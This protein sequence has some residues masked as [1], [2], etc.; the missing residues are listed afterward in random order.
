MTAMTW[1]QRSLLVVF[2]SVAAAEAAAQS[3]KEAPLGQSV[4]R[5]LSADEPITQWLH[6]PKF[7]ET[8]AGDRFELR[9]VDG[10]ALETVKLKNVIPPIR[11]ASG[12]AD[13]PDQFVATLRKTLDSVRER[14]N[15]RLHLVGHA[16]TQP[17]SDALARIYG[18]NAG[19]SRERAGEVAEYLQRALMLPPDA[20]TYEWA[21][22]TQ[23]IAT[24]ASEEGRALNRRVEVEVWYDQPTARTT[25]EEVLVTND[26]K[27]V[28]VCRVETLCKLRFREGHARRARVKNLVPPLHYESDTTDLTPEFV[29]HVR[30]ALD[31]LRD[32]QNVVVKLI[33]YTDDAPL[34][35]RDARIYGD[36]LALSKAKAYR[37]A[38]ALAETLEL[39]SGVFASDGRGTT[40]PLARND[41]SQGRA[42]NR[43]VEV[44]FWHD[45]PLQE[46]PDEPQL[47]PKTDGVE[48]V[49][50]VYDPP[51]GTI[52]PLALEHG[53]AVIPAG[54]VEQLRR[55][56]NEIS[57]KANAR[58]RFVGYTGNEVLD[59]RTAAVYGDDIG[60]STARARRAMQTVSARM[61]LA[62][63]QAEHEGR[64]YVHS[65]DV[66]NAGFTQERESIVMVQAVYDEPAALDDY[67]GVDITP[68]TR[69]LATKNAFGLNLMHISVD[70]EPIDD[71]NRSSA[72]VQRCTDVA[73]EAA[74]IQ[75]RFDNLTSSPRLSVSAAPAAVTVRTLDRELAIGEPVRF[76]MYANYWSFI[77]HAEVRI[78]RSDQSVDDAPQGLVAVD[79]HGIAEWQ[80]VVPR[81]AVSTQGFKYVL[82]AY[83]KDGQFDDTRPQLLSV[84]ETAADAAA[85]TEE[86]NDAYGAASADGEAT[87]PDTPLGNYGENQL[88][89]Q[90]IRLGSGTVKV[91]GSAIPPDYRVWV[92]GRPVPVDAS[93]NF[94]AEAVL[95]SGMHTVEVAVLDDDGNGHLYLR[96]L[97][98]P[99]R[100]RFY[101]G[102]ADL[103][104]SENRTNGPADLL[105]GEN[106]PFDPDSNV[107]GRLAFYATEKLADHW[108]VTA[109]ADTREGPVEDLF[110]NF[111]DKSPDSLF[112]RMDPDIHYPTFGDDAI[113]E[114]MAPT[115]GKLYVKVSHDESHAMWGNFKVGY[116]ENELAQVDR[117]LYGGNL[118]WQS[119]ATTSFGEQRVALD[120]FAAEPGTVASREEFRGTGGSLYFLHNQDILTGSERVRIE[121]RD[122]DSGLVTGVVNLQ[123]V[124]DY[125]I[126][127][128]QGRILLSEPL[129]STTDDDMLVRSGGLSGQHAYL[130]VRYE[131]TPGL[132]DIDAMNTGGQASAWVTDW[133]K[134]GITT[135]DNDD[136]DMDSSLRGGDL[137]LRKSANTYLKLQGGKSEGLLMSSF[138]SED[139]GF[140][141]APQDDL[142]MN[143]ASADGYRADLAIGFEDVYSRAK[144]NLM[145]YTQQ[146][147]A[148]YSAPG[149]T[150]LADRDNYGATLH[151]PFGERVE[152][153]AKADKKWQALGLE[154]QTQEVDIAFQMTPKWSLATG[155][156]K[157]ARTDDSPVVPV[158]QDTGDRTDAVV[159][160][161]YDSLE[162]W[163]VYTF[164]QDTLST[165]DERE[166]N[167]RF[168]A[169][170]SYRFG[171]KLRTSMEV[172][173]GDLGLG[174]KVGT[175]YMVNEATDVY[176]NYSLEQ[177]GVADGVRGR[178]RS[179]ISGVKRRLSDSTSMYHEERYQS[180]STASGLTHATGVTLTARERW[181]FGANSE[182]GTLSN[183]ETG[184]ETDRKAGGIRVAYDLANVQLS[185]GVEY[186]FDDTE[187]LDASKVDRTTWLFRNNF[188]VQLGPDWR[189]VGKVDHSQSDSSL[190]QFYDG[191]YT[192]AVLGYGYRPVANDRLN[193]LVKY[194]YFYN[195]PT[196]DQVTPQQLAAEYIQKSHIASIDVTYDLTD[197]WTI[198]GKYAY[199]IG[200]LSLDRDDPEFFDNGAQLYIVRA[201]W[202]LGEKW[203]GMVEA[204]MLDLPDLDEQRA[205]ALVGLY[206]Y[207]GDHVKVGVGY[208]FTD[209]SEDLTDLSYDSHGA[210]LNIVGSM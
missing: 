99:K 123:P 26:F 202:R 79:E 173:D 112:R 33:G 101:V 178:G 167:D 197:R 92:A 27:K 64:G 3:T 7:F 63:T 85:D 98:L 159:Q 117:G 70:G 113:V 42:L 68:V 140:G 103:T 130:V 153:A 150:T 135:S 13:I 147:E 8:E 52:A 81:R 46:L 36:H 156:R 58:L 38:L 41:T 168:G 210:F 106:A 163:R 195:V 60:L 179:L 20:I 100:D 162:A 109:S 49:T 50:K 91:H 72:D 44:Q 193:A 84:I 115:L 121:L 14:R 143:D 9:D 61:E 205:G 40:A 83:G 120:G 12:V 154:T 176:V 133:M 138:R 139:G 187:Q 53:E 124:I 192:E 57:D 203:E 200:E 118:H 148:G 54:Y 199:R 114:E 35:E 2:V 97:E 194:T 51:W 146:L 23:P 125:D 206:R 126:D 119:E 67:E 16:D 201:D 69:E 80:P 188:R 122:K 66:V 171:E 55:A 191:G 96:D 76:R 32:K 43:R 104:V 160:L 152:L 71:P 59:R 87:A 142:S 190:G 5:H 207:F 75:L 56:L 180:S 82:R 25:Q 110:T 137:T 107:D 18:D 131:Y 4:E 149:F 102:I 21:G 186:R 89:V 116:A 90:N 158:T 181:S 183:D 95:P 37:V 182:V 209:F 17:L 94:I 105:Q 30:Q 22:D 45:D 73:L 93:G 169:G 208:N 15:V 157:D 164:A 10:E 24:N 145:L 172:S 108:Q 28:K 174:G 141:F 74:D 39:P 204:R 185:S 127:Y 134:L 170:G 6:D 47:C 198:G 19:L 151:V 88:A 78:F 31:N 136:G 177:E 86:T 155:V 65:N 34:S 165:T 111:L 161:G 77:D 189:V 1:K 129:A 144:G 132:I 175:S 11:F 128:L 196:T 184:A 48:T 29:A 62:P 166:E